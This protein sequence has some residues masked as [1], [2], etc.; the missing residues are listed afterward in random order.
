[1]P[2]AVPVAEVLARMGRAA[3]LVHVPGVLVP[4]DRR[5]F[6]RAGDRPGQSASPASHPVHL[7]DEFPWLAP[8]EHVRERPALQAGVEQAGDQCGVNR[9]QLGLG[10]GTGRATPFGECLVG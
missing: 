3:E 4:V 9:R 5:A 1:M 8:A 6:R 2:L 7:A 10:G